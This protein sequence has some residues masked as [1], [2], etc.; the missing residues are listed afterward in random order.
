LKQLVHFQEI[1]QTGHVIES[2]LDTVIFNLVASTIPKWQMFKLLSWME[3]GHQST[4]EHEWLRLVMRPLL[5][6][7]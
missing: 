7:S 1:Q 5:C 6:D 3:N 4:G 2:G